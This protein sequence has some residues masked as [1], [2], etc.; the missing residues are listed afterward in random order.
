MKKYFLLIFSVF[1]IACSPSETNTAKNTQNSELIT[2]N[3]W[4]MIVT[5]VHTITYKGHTK[6]VTEDKIED[7]PANTIIKWNSKSKTLIAV[8]DG[9]EVNL[10]P[11]GE[12][13]DG[14]LVDSQSDNGDI[15]TF[16]FSEIKNNKLIQIYWDHDPNNP[17]DFY[18]EMY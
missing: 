3:D 6:E 18:S 16:D 10:S 17:D 2:D 15:S 11:F 13:I 5:K 12:I 1:L 7:F 9:N 4:E 14:K 8:M